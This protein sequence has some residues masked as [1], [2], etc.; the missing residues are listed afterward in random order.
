MTAPDGSS[1]LV[2]VVPHVGE[3]L[4]AGPVLLL[5]VAAAVGV[6]LQVRGRRRRGRPA[7]SDGG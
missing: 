6:V 3:A 7:G 2:V 1:S 4:A 5:V